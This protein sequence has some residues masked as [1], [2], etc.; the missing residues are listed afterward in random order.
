VFD[1]TP[2]GLQALASAKPSFAIDVLRASPDG[3]AMLAISN[4]VEVLT[5]FQLAR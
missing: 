2:D 5:V 4:P 3:K 1:V